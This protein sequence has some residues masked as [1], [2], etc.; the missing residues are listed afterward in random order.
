MKGGVGKTRV[1][2]RG[3]VGVRRAAQAARDRY[4]RQPDLRWAGRLIDPR[5]QTS[6]REFL[7]A[8]NLVDYPKARFYTGQNKQGLEVLA[9]NQNVANPMALEA[10]TFTRP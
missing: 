5:T 7:A 10:M 9:G 3:G 8:E 2:R 4:R 1:T 6:V